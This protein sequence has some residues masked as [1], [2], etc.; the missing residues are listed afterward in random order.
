MRDGDGQ[1]AG[2]GDGSP[3]ASLGAVTMER[4]PR[5]LEGSHPAGPVLVTP[6]PAKGDGLR[7]SAVYRR[8][9]RGT[10]RLDLL[11]K[12]AVPA[13]VAGLLRGSG[14]A[15]AA[16]RTRRSSPRVT[17]VAGVRQHPAREPREDRRPGRDHG[18]L[19]SARWVLR[20]TQMQ[21]TLVTSE[22]RG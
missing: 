16:A 13:I 4:W 12:V 11:P 3:T 5:A 2:D 18:A 8:G 9:P 7:V 21:G 14:A 1:G 17:D 10:A 6:A 15:V 20:A 19:H 22:E